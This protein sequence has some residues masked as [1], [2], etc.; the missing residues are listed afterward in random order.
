MKL[1]KLYD[2]IVS[3]LYV[4]SPSPPPT[5]T[6]INHVNKKVSISLPSVTNPGLRSK[7]RTPGTIFKPLS[8]K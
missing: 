2:V 1:T 6:H 3:D 5:H 8:V 4:I 7:P